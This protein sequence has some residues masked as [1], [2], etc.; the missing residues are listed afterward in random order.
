M[1]HN[2]LLHLTTDGWIQLGP[3]ITFLDLLR[4]MSLP[5]KMREL[6]VR[7]VINFFYWLSKA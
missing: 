3:K 1:V 6:W 4:T 5:G 2:M 7:E